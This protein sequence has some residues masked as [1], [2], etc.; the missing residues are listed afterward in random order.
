[1]SASSKNQFKKELFVI[2]QNIDQYGYLVSLEGL[3]PT[4]IQKLRQSLNQSKS[5]LH[6]YK[7]KIAQHAII[8]LRDKTFKS[9]PTIKGRLFLIQTN[10]GYFK[11]KELLQSISVDTYF[12]PGDILDNKLIIPAGPTGLRPSNKTS[13][14]AT[15][16]STKLQKGYLVIKED[17]HFQDISK[18][19]SEDECFILDF[20]NIRAKSIK[21]NIEYVLDTVNKALLSLDYTLLSDL[22][23]LCESK[24]LIRLLPANIHNLSTQFLMMNKQLLLLENKLRLNYPRLA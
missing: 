14:L 3:T 19:I 17:Y 22:S 24:K 15:L 4:L 20:F 13:R 12:K 6:L 21:P 18:A 5:T 9:L 2:Y 7:S 8:S 16:L 11:L 1:M 10:L 23:F